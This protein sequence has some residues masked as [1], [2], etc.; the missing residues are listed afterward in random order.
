M[1]P[2]PGGDG[3][4]VV[5]ADLLAASAAFSSEGATYKAIVPA[6]GPACPDGGSGAV[7]QAMQTVAE[8]IGAL[9]LQAAGVIESDSAKLKTAHDKYAS[10][11][12][13]LTQLCNQ[14]SSPLKIN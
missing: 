2:P 13:S 11:E 14:I 8:L 1:A 4:Q 9:H 7:N 12:E 10:T 5:M 3:Y 6:D